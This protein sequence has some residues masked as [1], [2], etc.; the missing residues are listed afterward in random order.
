M[1]RSAALISLLSSAPVS[2]VS[3]LDQQLTVAER[4]VIPAA[5]A[6]PEEHYDFAPAQGEFG[7]VRT[8]IEQVK[9]I[10][11][12]NY[13]ILS[14]VRTEQ[15]PEHVNQGRG[16][17]GLRTRAEALKYLKES[18][19]FAHGVIATLTTESILTPVAN[20]GGGPPAS[21]MALV[22]IAAIHAM[23]H[24]GQMVVYLRMNG[25]VPPATQKEI[26]QKKRGTKE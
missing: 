7:G 3:E 18:Y 5:E 14:T 22:N 15:P 17:D 16:P 21:R 19:A 12:V 11:A 4:R 23:D 2:V 10:A 25:I 6:M 26:E 13:L 24:Y 9:H 20:P 8:F 1:L